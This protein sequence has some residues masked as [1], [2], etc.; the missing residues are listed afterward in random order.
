MRFDTLLLAGFFVVTTN[1][2]AQNAPIFSTKGTQIHNCERNKERCMVDIFVQTV[3]QGTRKCTARIEYREIR[4]Y[5]HNNH[6]RTKIKVVWI[7]RDDIYGDTMKYRFDLTKGIDIKG[8]DSANDFDEPGVDEDPIYKRKFKWR[9]LNKKQ[10]GR[11][12]EINVVNLGVTGTEVPVPCDP[13]D[14]RIVNRN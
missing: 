9:S 3:D 10:N 2:L 1:V 5:K 8:N 13:V 7:L 12:Y 6:P 11:A 14:P 4:V